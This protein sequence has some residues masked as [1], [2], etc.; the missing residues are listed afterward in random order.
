ML[1][2]LSIPAELNKAKV[3]FDK[4]A[5]DGA[6][7]E[8]KKISPPRSVNQNSYIH[9]LFTLWGNHFGYTVEEAKQVVKTELGYTYIKEGILFMVR[10]SGMDSKELTELIDK[11]RN[12]SAHQGCYLPTSEEYL[13]RHFDYTQEIER[14]E[15]MQKRY[16]Y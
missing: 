13:L 11:F 15:I 9:V 4:L 2:N 6:K 5:S 7:I 10:T 1:L 3:Y 14:A 12:W 8:L 16:G